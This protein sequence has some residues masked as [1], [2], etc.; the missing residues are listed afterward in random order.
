MERNRTSVRRFWACDTPMVSTRRSFGWYCM[1]LGQPTL[2]VPIT[3]TSSSFHTVAHGRRWSEVST[4]VT[5]FFL[6]N[7]CLLI[8]VLLTV[9]YGGDGR[10]S[11]GRRMSWHPR[12]CQRPV[13]Q[14]GSLLAPRR[15]PHCLS[16]P[17]HG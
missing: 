13:V 9:W 3:H 6:L 11:P 2:S 4:R 7:L 12:D 15:L 1:A 14:V 16:R 5:R 17:P 10:T 8:G